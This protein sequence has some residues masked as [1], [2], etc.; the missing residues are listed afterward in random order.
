MRKELFLT[1]E[2]NRRAAEFRATESFSGLA[3]RLRV[4]VRPSN[5]KPPPA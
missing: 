2:E 1:L 5:P 4:P 3:A